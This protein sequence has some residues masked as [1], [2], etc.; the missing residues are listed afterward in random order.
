[1]NRSLTKSRML[2]LH[3]VGAIALTMAPTIVAAQNTTTTS[4]RHG[5]PSH[6]ITVKNAQVVYVEGN[7]LV[8]KLEDGKVEHMIVPPNEKFTVDGR[9]GT[10]RDLKAGSRLTQTIT[11]TTTPR[12]VQTV[13]VIKG[14]VWH[15]TPPTSV[16]VSLPDGQNHHYRVPAH[17]KFTVDGQPKT[18]F[19]LRKG[20]SFEATIVTDSPETVVA[21]N[22]TN[23]AVTPAPPTPA[24]MGVLLLDQATPDTHELMA[25][26]SAEHVNSQATLP[27]TASAVPLFGLLGLAGIGS[28]IGLWLRRRSARIWQ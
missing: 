25:S 9:E 17:A 11:T 18:V 22:K 12:Y 15:V 28:S 2:A 23:H 3:V 10:V 20:M 16:I 5:D 7:D 1:M 14:K 4:V 19:D 6:E 27:A 26:V 13:Q 24:W 21:S 8:L